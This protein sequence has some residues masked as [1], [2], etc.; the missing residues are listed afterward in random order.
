MNVIHIAGTK[1][2][3]STCAFTESILRSHGKRTGSPRK[4]GLYTSPHLIDPNE[5]VRINSEPISPDL[6]AKYF[7]ELYDRLPQLAS[8]YDASK[9]PIERGPRYLQLW[10]LIAFH[11]FI[12][13]G[14]DVAI[15]ETHNGGEYDATNVVTKPLVTAVATLGMDHIDMLGPSIEN[16][17]WHKSGIYKSGAVALSTTQD[18]APAKVLEQRAAAKGEVLRVVAIDPCLPND[19]LALQPIVQKKNA[20]LAAATASAYLEQ[21]KSTDELTTDDIAV[22]CEQFNWPGRFQRVPDGKCA[23]FLDA[24]HNDMSVAIAAKWFSESCRAL[25]KPN[26][27]F[28]RV[29]IFSHINELRDTASLLESLASAFK[30]SVPGVDHVIFSTYD[31][32]DERRARKRGKSPELFHETWRKLLP[33]TSIWDEPTIQRAI[34]RARK[35]DEGYDGVQTLITGSQ[36]LVGPA[37]RVLK[38]AGAKI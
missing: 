35:L 16:I 14:V 30:A 4:T 19:V 24:A 21:I 17:A 29:L 13:E 23:W 26:E 1:G 15:L 27:N 36:H 37:L 3:G 10:A 32:S 6:L 31:E 9:P 34:E 28:V 22:G 2:K 12:R 5:R 7:F 8:E 25:Q 38:K 11:T 20:S 18:D 33:D